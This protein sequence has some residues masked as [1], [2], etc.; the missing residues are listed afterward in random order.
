MK[1]SKNVKVPEGFP[2]GFLWGGATAANQYEGAYME[3]GKL[4]SVADV[5]PHGVFGYPDRNAKYYP[6]HEGIDFYHHYK[7]DIA[8]FGE[9]GFKVYRTS[10]AWTRI[11][12][13]GEETEPNEKGLEFYDKVFE[14][15]RKH[16]ME[17]MVTISH[18]EMPLHLA[19]KYGGWKD[20]RMINFYTKFV[21]TM[22]ADL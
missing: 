2:E 10:V 14:E 4:P 20:R 5:Q 17:V 11:Y 21:K 18:Y 8:E 13:T 6:T 12:P 9:M 3:D 16:G 1:S 22:V 7:E 19:D 15:C